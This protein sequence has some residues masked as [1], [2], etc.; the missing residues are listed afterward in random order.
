M[1]IL[2]Q[3][4]VTQRNKRGDVSITYNSREDAPGEK[5]WLSTTTLPYEVVMTKS[6]LVNQ[7]DRDVLEARLVAAG[8]AQY[9]DYNLF[10]EAGAGSSSNP[11]PLVLVGSGTVTQTQVINTTK[12]VDL[13]PFV[14]GGYEP[15]T[16]AIGTGTFTQ[17]TPT[18]VGTYFR[19]V[20]GATAG[21]D[22][23][24]V[25]VTDRGGNTVTITVTATVTA[26]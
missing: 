6:V 25:I 22:T 4:Q 10:T 23:V 9:D 2:P 12:T 16:Y 5:L 24:P 13:D 3:E 1:A 21:S 7:Q 11:Q 8:E 18:M 19:F 26:T 20:A 17:G 15:L 14:D